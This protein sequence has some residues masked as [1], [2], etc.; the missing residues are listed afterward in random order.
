MPTAALVLKYSTKLKAVA[1]A[2]A[3][4]AMAWALSPTRHSAHAQFQMLYRTN[5]VLATLKF[6]VW[7]LHYYCAR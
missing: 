6:T 7:E 2:Q 3:A 4:Q 5:C 1:T